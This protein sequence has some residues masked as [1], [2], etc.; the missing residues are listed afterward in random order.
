MCDPIANSSLNYKRDKHPSTAQKNKPELQQSLRK[1]LDST[2]IY[3]NKSIYKSR[4]TIEP[5]NKKSS[6]KQTRQLQ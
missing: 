2:T 3:Q 1:L 6:N 4:N 5:K